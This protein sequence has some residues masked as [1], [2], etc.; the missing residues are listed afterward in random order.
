MRR[1]LMFPLLPFALASLA[2]CTAEYQPAGPS[3]I[4]P[5]LQ[6][7]AMRMPDGVNLAMRVTPARGKTHAVAIALHGINDYSRA[8]QDAMGYWAEEGITV[9]AYDQRGF[10][11]NPRPG[12][13][14]TA[15]TLVDDL[16]TAVALV[17]KAHPE[18][19]LFLIGESMGSAV[20]MS[21]LGREDPPQVDGAVLGAPAVWARQTMSG[22]YQRVLAGMRSMF[23]GLVLTG[24]GLGR[25][26]TDNIAELIRMG[27]DPLV[28]KGARVD[29]IAGLVNLMDQAYRA[30]PKIEAPLLLLYGERDE[31]VPLHAVRQT[32]DRFEIDPV[33]AV[34]PD[35][36]HM[37]YRD[38]NSPVLHND[39]RHWILKGG[40][41]LPS[42]ANRN[43]DVL[44]RPVKSAAAD[45]A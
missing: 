9:Y 21:A 12:I 14:P 18:L 27:R 13:W 33:I 24:S 16:E 30:A 23:P 44:T 20:I 39:V 28:V 2:A 4:S 7:D 35:G 5:A 17:R 25:Q 10:G 8:W 40:R 37:L 22:T 43:A 26:A 11:A 3:T 6:K 31:I 34:Y 42:G 38:L 32:V 1:L 29:A 41:A 15:D 19:P 45:P 36:W